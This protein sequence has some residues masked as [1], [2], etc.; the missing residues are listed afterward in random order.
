MQKP[1]KE[2]L[3]KARDNFISAEESLCECVENMTILGDAFKLTIRNVKETIGDLKCCIYL[4]DKCLK[5]NTSKWTP[6]FDCETCG[7]VVEKEND[8]DHPSGTCT[9]CPESEPDARV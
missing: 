3:N 9:N 6:P 8:Y 4:I 7:S 2:I 1:S 5:E